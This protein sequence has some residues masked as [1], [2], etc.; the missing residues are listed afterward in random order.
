MA[1]MACVFWDESNVAAQQRLGQIVR[2]AC[3]M[4]VSTLVGSPCIS[5]SW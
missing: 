3:L 4:L 2:G 1:D 5:W